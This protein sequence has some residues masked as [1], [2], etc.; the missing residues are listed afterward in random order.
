MKDQDKKRDM[1]QFCLNMKERYH[2]RYDDLFWRFFE[3]VIPPN[4]KTIAEYGVGPGLFL[5]DAIERFSLKE[6]WAFDYSE[7]MLEHATQHL[8]GVDA[9]IHFE[10]VDLQNEVPQNVPPESVDIIFTGFLF[11]ALNKPLQLLENWKTILS[12]KGTIVI[13]DFGK[14]ELR[15][16]EKEWSQKTEASFEEILDR[17]RNFS[18]YSTDDLRLLFERARFREIANISRSLSVIFAATH[19]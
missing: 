17:Y 14:F 19:A 18:R 1:Y 15:M 3:I 6:A 16:F 12:P 8:Q 4:S 11:R 10:K 13:Y 7:V 5:R 2:T 9:K